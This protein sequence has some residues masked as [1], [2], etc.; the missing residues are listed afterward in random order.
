MCAMTV[1]NFVCPWQR[2][3]QY[4]YLAAAMILVSSA[5]QSQRLWLKIA[6]HVFASSQELQ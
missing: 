2:T 4:A 1:T 3:A 6:L 5:L